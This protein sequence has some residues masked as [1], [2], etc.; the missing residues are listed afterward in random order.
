MT[1]AIAV[2]RIKLCLKWFP[3]RSV[4]PQRTHSRGEKAEQFAPSAHS[5]RECQSLKEKLFL[6]QLN[7]LQSLAPMYRQE[8][9]SD[10]IWNLAKQ[11]SI[12]A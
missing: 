12:T 8:F 6:S 9:F 3:P 1:T 10:H 7:E 5:Q 2:I 4:P 11:H